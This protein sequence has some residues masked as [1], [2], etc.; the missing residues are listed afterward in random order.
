VSIFYL[1]DIV[2]LDEPGDVF[3]DELM[4]PRGEETGLG[5]AQAQSLHREGDHP[6]QDGHWR[7]N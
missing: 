1:T 2:A 4:C 3:D 6:A 7:S 5:Q